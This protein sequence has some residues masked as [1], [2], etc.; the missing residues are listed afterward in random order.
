LHLILFLVYFWFIGG[1][2]EGYYIVD[3]VDRVY[4]RN[5]VFK[6]HRDKVILPGRTHR[7]NTHSK[8]KIL[9]TQIGS[10]SAVSFKTMDVMIKETIMEQQQVVVMQ[11]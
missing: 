10:D 3:D 7:Y 6:C 11:K 8:Y 2:G 5:E 1:G 4:C 9:R